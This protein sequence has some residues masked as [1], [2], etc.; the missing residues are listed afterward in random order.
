M[1][2]GRE[3]GELKEG[4]SVIKKVILLEYAVKREILVDMFAVG[5]ILCVLFVK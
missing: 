3:Q 4:C 1:R 5:P 2:R